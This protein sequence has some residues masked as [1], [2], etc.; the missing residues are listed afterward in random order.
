MTA[1]VKPID[2]SFIAERQPL[3]VLRVRHDLGG[4]SNAASRR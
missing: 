2:G 4:M 1:L 3:A